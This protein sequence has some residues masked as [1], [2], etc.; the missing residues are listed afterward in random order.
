M[1]TRCKEVNIEK[2]NYTVYNSHPWLLVT[3]HYTEWS[4]ENAK[5]KSVYLLQKSNDTFRVKGSVRK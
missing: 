2:E 1:F 4:R 5:Q 3:G